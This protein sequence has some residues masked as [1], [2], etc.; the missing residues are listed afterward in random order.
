MGDGRQAEAG[1]TEPDVAKTVE[2]DQFVE[3]GVNLTDIFAGAGLGAPAV[4][5]LV[6][7]RDP[8]LVVARRDAEGL[9]PRRPQLLQRRHQ[10]RP[11]GD[12]P[13]RRA[14]HVRGRCRPAARR[15][16]VAAPTVG[17]VDVT[18]TGSDGITAGDIIVAA[19]APAT[20]RSRRGDNLDAQRSMHAHGEFDQDGQVTGHATVSVNVGGTP[21]PSSLAS[22]TT[23]GGANSRR[24][25]SRPTSTPRSTSPATARTGSKPATR[26]QST[27]MADD[28]DGIG[29]HA[30][31]RSD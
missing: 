14:A 29:P 1:P 28:G 17:D 25:P 10:D 16:L 20:T 21:G 11:V 24:R 12:Q 18:L 26:S 23:I 27:L 30:V 3:G 2:P 15:R 22:T 6:P 13:G 31:V 7:C 5:R 9:R 4:L 19:A 8:F